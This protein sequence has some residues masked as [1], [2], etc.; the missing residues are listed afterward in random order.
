MMRT[1]LALFSI[2]IP[3]LIAAAQQQGETQPTYVLRGKFA[4]TDNNTYRALPFEVPAGT[5]RITIVFSHTQAEQRTVI[6][7]GLYD[8]ERLRGWSGS[9]KKWFTISEVDATPSYLP[10]PLQPGIWSLQLGVP[11]IRK[12]VT[13]EYTAKIYLGNS[14]ELP[15]IA[16]TAPIKIRTTP[17]WYEGDLHTHT[18]HSDG[19]CGSKIG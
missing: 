1:I 17:G 7:L 3:G 5:R 14:E 13:S 10:G 16:E 8:T 2:L 6:D 15:N 19:T 9:D 4:D 11:N 18:G 12:G